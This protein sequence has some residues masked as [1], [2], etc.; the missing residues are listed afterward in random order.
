MEKFS[1]RDYDMEYHKN[2]LKQIKFNLNKEHE[3]DLIELLDQQE[4]K[5][6]FIKSLLMTRVKTEARS[7][8]VFSNLLHEIEKEC[9]QLKRLADSDGDTASWSKYADIANLLHQISDIFYYE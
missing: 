8:V 1:K 6:A 9:E 4:N 3:Q 5:Q 7:T 2:N